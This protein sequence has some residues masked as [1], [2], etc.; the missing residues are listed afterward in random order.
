M[1][2]RPLAHRAMAVSAISLKL[3]DRFARSAGQWSELVLAG[4]SCGINCFEVAGRNPALV[5]GV[6][7]A[8]R[9]VE[10]RLLFVA[11][12]FGPSV[13]PSAYAREAFSP[14]A[15][16]GLAKAVIART[17][18]AYLDLVQLDDPGPQDLRPEGLKMLRQLKTQG[19]VQNIGVA[20]Q[21]ESMD[22][23]I[24]TG[25]FEVLTLPFS[26]LSGSLERR[27]L[28]AAEERNMSVLGTSPYPEAMLT[29]SQAAPRRLLL[30]WNAKAET[31]N[32]QPYRFL[33][34]TPQWTAEELAVAYALTEPSLA[35]VQVEARD[36]GHLQALAAVAERELPSSLPAQIEMARFSTLGQD[37]RRA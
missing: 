9:T 3:D 36:V 23:Y 33:N 1:R 2:Y 4:L 13:M 20:G 7:Q 21:G 5:D 30:G 8:L 17:G 25:A 27:R 12:R 34:T 37:A 14:V 18:L 22:A 24:S 19:L 15:L 31:P 11:W 29:V 16:E 6:S 32:A 26:M 28:R 10:R 35:T